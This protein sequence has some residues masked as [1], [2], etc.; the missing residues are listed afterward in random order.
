MPASCCPRMAP[1]TM[2]HNFAWNSKLHLENTAVCSSKFSREI[3][4]GIQMHVCVCGKW[5]GSS[6]YGGWRRIQDLHCGLAQD[7]LETQES[8][9]CS[10]RPSPKAWEPGLQVMDFLVWKTASSRSKSQCFGSVLKAGKEQCLSSRKQD[11]KSS[12]LLEESSSC[13]TRTFNWLDDDHPH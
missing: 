12:L 7:R 11:R 9:W 13:S 6:D 2:M 3:T 5:I 8:W 4:S 1:W 10:S